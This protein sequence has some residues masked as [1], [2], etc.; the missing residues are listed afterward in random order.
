MNNPLKR[1][2]AP[3]RT[4]IHRFLRM[5]LIFIPVILCI[6][7][8]VF[9]YA[10]R[11]IEAEFS[12]INLTNTRSAAE[13]MKKLTRK[14]RFI[15]ASL[16]LDDNARAFF[17]DSDV[18]E[19]TE[20]A[21]NGQITSYLN[22]Y[23]GIESI[24]LYSP[25]TGQVLTGLTYYKSTTAAAN[26]R[27]LNDFQM[28]SGML[29]TPRIQEEGYPYV[30]TA[31][32]RLNEYGYDGV[33]VVNISLNAIASML[34]VQEDDAHSFYI[35]NESGEVLYRKNKQ[36]LLEDAARFSDLR[37]FE[38][39]QE[40]KTLLDRTES[41]AF[42]WSQV[43]NETTGL[44]FVEKTYM[45]EYTERMS[46]LQGLI[47]SG[48]MILLAMFLCVAAY[49]TCNALRPLRHLERVL[50]QGEIVGGKHPQDEYT[51][52]LTQRIM[53]QIQ[54]NAHF[55]EMLTDQLILLEKTQLRSLRSQINPHFLF[56]TLNAISMQVAGGEDGQSRAIAMIGWLSELLRYSLAKTDSV[57][58]SME[59]LQTRN[60]LNLLLAR[61]DQE[62]TVELSVAPGLDGCLV[63]RL[64]LQPLIENAVFHG[65]VPLEGRQGRIQIQIDRQ[66]NSLC[67]VVEDNGIGMSAETLEQLRTQL[68]HLPEE[69]PEKHIGLLNVAIRLHLMYPASPPVSVESAADVFTRFTLL[70]PLE[71]P[72][73]AAA[74]EDA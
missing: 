56:N 26:I 13:E 65:V 59:I 40:D 58:L 22:T 15:T 34:G 11:T 46:M 60:Y 42:V 71:S 64:L 55:R 18:F 23:E 24:Y 45:T 61:Y 54:S 35:L 39:T 2:N 41:R 5:A 21:L 19:G 62:F 32:R 20:R 25:L 36:A 49:L 30:L 1:Q 70:I 4:A 68:A 17:T 10:E 63:P 37:H 72:D 53:A 28:A 73:P 6:T 8:S 57:P 66:D 48:A 51:R 27:W 9:L 38:K 50:D 33:A 44:Y 43:Y 47:F 14:M 31:I 3:H 16:L 29:L 7:L 52:Y 12:S 74:S 67:V 69:M